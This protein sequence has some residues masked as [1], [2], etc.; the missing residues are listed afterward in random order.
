[1]VTGLQIRAARGFLAWDR[2]YLAK[3]AVVTI[4]TLER[5]ET[6][7]EISGSAM[8]KGLAAIQAALE[9]EGIEFT[10]DK[11]VPGVRLHAKKR[12]GK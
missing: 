2:R 10:D 7:A 3:K 1:V 9:A 11:G 5:I 4:Y 8:V 6:G 12:K